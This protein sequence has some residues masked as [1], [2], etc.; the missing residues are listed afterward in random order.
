MISNR[1]ENFIN[2]A[3]EASKSSQM[4]MK[5][6]CVVVSSNRIVGTGYN[7]QRTR[8]RN[9]FTADSCSCHAE[10]HAL[11]IAMRNFKGHSRSKKVVQGS[12]GRHE[13]CEHQIQCLCS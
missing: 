5:H 8:F 11:N 2:R 13:R 12:K 1:D 6:G 4:H 9:N 10:M 7:S 3:I